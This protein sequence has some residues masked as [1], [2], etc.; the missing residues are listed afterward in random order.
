MFMFF[1]FLNIVFKRKQIRHFYAI[2]FI[3]KTNI[4][5][6]VCELEYINSNKSIKNRMK[7]DSNK[8]IFVFFIPI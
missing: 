2:V 5:I 1:L 7:C 3:S 6:R 8:P 4:E